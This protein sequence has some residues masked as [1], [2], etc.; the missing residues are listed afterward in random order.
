[1]Y[2]QEEDRRHV[3]VRSYVASSRYPIKQYSL[4]LT[5][6]YSKRIYVTSK[7]LSVRKVGFQ[8]AD[9]P[10]ASG[11]HKMA[12]KLECLLNS[13][14]IPHRVQPDQTRHIGAEKA[15]SGYLSPYGTIVV[16]GS[17]SAINGVASGC[18]EHR[19]HFCGLCQ[20]VCSSPRIVSEGPTF[21]PLR[22][23]E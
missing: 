21:F 10:G 13:S 15:V 5:D 9:T 8:A 19:V 11:A 12:I 2:R 3:L 1:M 6:L 4:V 20:K 18:C 14:S 22:V 16:V 7:G 17:T 23:P